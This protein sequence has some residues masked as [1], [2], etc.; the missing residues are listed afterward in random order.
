MSEL[1]PDLKRLI[2]WSRGAAPIELE[3]APFGFARRVLAARKRLESPTLLD[4]L[5]DTARGIA[6]GSLALIA[7]GGVFW[8]S[9]P[10]A[11]APAAEISSALNFVANN[12]SQ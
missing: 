12:F 11:P 3:K 6:F 10:S 9:Q 2:I 8:I 5:R 4:E 1:D 7:V